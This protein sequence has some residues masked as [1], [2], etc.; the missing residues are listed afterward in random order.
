[1]YVTLNPLDP[2]LLARANNRLKEQGGRAGDCAADANV[3]A[4]RWLLVDVDPVKLAGVSAT[5]GEKAAARTVT[6]GVRQDLDGRGWPAPMVIDSGNGYHLWYR[7]ELPRDDG[8]TVQGILT[9]LARKHDTAA[10]TVDTAVFNPSRIAKL[11]GTWA[12]KG[13]SL[14]DRPHRMA[15]ILEVP[16]A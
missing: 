3:L 5:D 14:P 9:G 13:D 11:P 6:D 7:V 15:R 2:V 8:G 12:R 16:G 1:V 4:R 10:A